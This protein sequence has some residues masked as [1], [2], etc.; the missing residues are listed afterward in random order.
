MTRF[1]QD[2]LRQPDELR[3]V[4]AHLN[5]AGRGLVESSAHTI[6]N[7]RHTYVTGIGA[8]W[9][10][11]LGAGSIFHSGGWPVYMLDAAELLQFSK[12]PPQ[13][14]I[15]VLS[16][17]GRSVEIVRLLAKANEA[18]ATVIGVT[19][20]E[21]GPLALEADVTVLVP[22]KADHGISV[23]TYSTL[24]AAAAAFAIATMSSFS[25]GLADSLANAV[26]ET[27]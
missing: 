25:Q 22:V 14:V 13:A 8:S 11:A 20:F 12:I 10:A 17:S 6:R 19:N 4:I 24:A 5:G 2:I 16:R 23:N 26:A 15:L 27:A 7:A 3:R 1:L 18:G 21:D 9:N